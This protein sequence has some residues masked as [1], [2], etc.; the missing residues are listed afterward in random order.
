MERLKCNSKNIQLSLGI[1]IFVIIS[2]LFLIVVSIALTRRKPSISDKKTSLPVHEFTQN[3]TAQSVALRVY[4]PE[5]LELVNIFA[6]NHDWIATLSA[7]HLRTIA[8]TG[9]VMLGRSVNTSVIR[10]GNFTSL[11]GGI[12][13]LLSKTDITLINL[14]SPI[15]TDCPLTESGM[16]FCADPRHI[17]GLISAGVDVVEFAN[18]HAGNYQQKGINETVS[19]LRGNG[20]SVAGIDETVIIP[21]RGVRFAF[22]AYND[23]GK[24]VGVKN[25]DEMLISEEIHE[26]RNRADIIVVLFHW[27]TEYTHRPTRRQR[28]LARY[29]V[30]QGADVVV[31]NHPHWVQGI[32]LYRGKPIVYSHGNFI[33]D[34]MWSEET[35]QGVV[36]TYT[37]FDTRL[38]DISFTPIYIE[39]GGKPGIETDEARK[40]QLLFSMEEE[41]AVY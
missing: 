28:Q 32:D 19:L 12:R 25:A 3:S 16:V 30:D 1:V 17:D 38:I 9:D 24:Q 6:K 33:F 21:I 41:S 13:E 37:F 34:Q 29:A 14:E 20:L 2:N 27:G 18:N 10:S 4:E 26:V 7:E 35:R 8:V 22:L 23:V 5:P 15:V 40:Q 31:G 11:Y 39:S 36:G